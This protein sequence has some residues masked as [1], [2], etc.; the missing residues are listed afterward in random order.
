MVLR[1]QD[2]D[3]VQK[4]I[5]DRAAIVLDNNKHYFVE[6]RLGPVVEEAGLKTI[7]E[8]VQMLKTKGTERWFQ[9]VTDFITHITEKKKR[10]LI[11]RQVLYLNK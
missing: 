3:F 6:S 9:R 5:Q 2:F 1:Q 11:Y 8:F 10:K 7:E 4:L